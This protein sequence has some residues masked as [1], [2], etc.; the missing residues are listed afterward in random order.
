MERNT[1]YSNIDLEEFADMKWRKLGSA[2]NRTL[3]KPDLNDWETRISN[4]YTGIDTGDDLPSLTDVEYEEEYSFVPESH[5]QEDQ[6]AHD[7]DDDYWHGYMDEEEYREQLE[8]AK[9]E[10]AA[11]RYEERRGDF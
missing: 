3:D 11:S 6:D 10:Q 1:T 7:D 5:D 8:L 9:Q 4:I 2:L